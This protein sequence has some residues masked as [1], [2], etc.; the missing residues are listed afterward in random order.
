MCLVSVYSPKRSVPLQVNGARAPRNYE[1]NST[2][3]PLADVMLRC[4]DGVVY[5]NKAVGA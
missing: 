1:F 5:V 3:S 4:H 2:S